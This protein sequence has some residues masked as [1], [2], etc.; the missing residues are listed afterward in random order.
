ML[1]MLDTYAPGAA[2][3]V[4]GLEG[5]EQVG[6][7]GNA[8]PGGEDSKDQPF[9]EAVQEGLNSVMAV[10]AQARR[11]YQQAGRR[12]QV[13][14]YPGRVILLRGTKMFKRFKGCVVDPHGGWGKFAGGGV[15]MHMINGH[16]TKLLREPKIRRLVRIIGGYLFDA[17]TSSA[18]NPTVRRS[19]LNRGSNTPGRADGQ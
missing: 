19:E 18:L 15:E 12:Y 10:Q 1:A 11:Q 7:R 16:H 4:P 3:S 8:L 13:K 14:P 17:Q 9:K 6:Q 2:Q 5:A